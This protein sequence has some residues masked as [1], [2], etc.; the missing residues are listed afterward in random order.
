MLALGGLLI[1]AA[2]LAL[3]A[4]APIFR[5]PDPPRWATW[6]WAEELATLAVVGALAMG[7]GWLVAGAA[8]A[9]QSGPELVD[10]GLLGAVLVVTVLIWRKLD[11]RARLRAL[12]ARAAPRRPGSVGRAD[13]SP[14]T[15]PASD[16]QVAPTEP[17]PPQPSKPS[18]RA[19]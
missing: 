3:A 9:V 18:R 7:V 17:P 2:V 4:L 8:R 16:V 10:L 12:E 15:A 1:C 11:P 6:S 5:R 14:A 19:A 13:L